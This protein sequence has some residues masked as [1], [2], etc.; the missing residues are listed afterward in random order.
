ME[1]KADKRS[2]YES[3]FKALALFGGVRVI[4]II[5]SIIRSKII[6][7]LIGPT[8]MGI[9]HLLKSTTD[10]VNHITGCGLHTSAVRDVAKAYDDND[11]ERINTTIST[12]RGLVWFTGLLGGII[13]LVFASPLS[14]FAFGNKEYASAFRI[15]SIMMVFMQLNV[16]QVALMQGTFHYKDMARATLLAQIMSLVLTIPLYYFFREKGIVPALLI[17]SIITVVFTSF[18]SK[19][20]VFSKVLMTLEDYWVNGREMISLGI[21]ISLGGMI[22]NASSYLMNVF[23]SRLGSVDAVGL[24]SAAIT[25]ANSYVFL[26]L[27]AMT[28]DYVPRI[29][30]LSS[31]SKLIIT[32]INKQMVMVMIV[33]VPLLIA[34]S[35]FAKEVLLVLYSSEFL[36]TTHMLEFLMLGMFFRAI[37]WCLSYALIARGESKVF[38]RNEIVIFCI[39]L[40]LKVL[41]FKFLGFT[42]IGLAIILV[43]FLY[44][45][46]LLFVC[47]RLFCFRLD[48]EFYKIAFPSLTL[49]VI[50]SLM[51]FLLGSLWLKYVLG[52]VVFVFSLLYSYQQLNARIHIKYLVLSKI[53]RS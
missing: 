10:T 38:L 1:E 13:V 26:V 46:I 31:D 22:S 43:Y 45:I 17:A 53:H 20:V 27:S 21:V 2:S 6:A 51:S 12:L 39:S 19:R 8:G 41:G 52:S 9:S 30:A 25:I 48:N 23:V 40:S 3:I 36:V 42:G 33:L 24:Y 28:S 15:L 35:V 34:F 7:L 37:S 44:T 4:Q 18:Y 29:S 47:K 50:A 49:C 16:G 14:Q 32:A 5:V 11:Q